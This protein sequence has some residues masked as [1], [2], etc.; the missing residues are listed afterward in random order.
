MHGDGCQRNKV[1]FLALFVV[2]CEIVCGQDRSNELNCLA[3]VC[4]F[5][6]DPNAVDNS[7]Q[8]FAVHTR[9]HKNPATGV[10]WPVEGQ[11]FASVYT[12]PGQKAMLASAGQIK[13]EGI[14]TVY[15]LNADKIIKFKYY[16]AV[17]KVDLRG[18]CDSISNCPWSAGADSKIS[19]FDH[20]QGAQFV[21]PIGTL[22]VLFFVDNH[23]PNQGSVAVDDIQLFCESDG[24]EQNDCPKIDPSP[25]FVASSGQIPLNSND[26]ENQV[27]QNASTK[28]SGIVQESG[29]SIAI[30]NATITAVVAETDILECQNVKKISLLSAGKI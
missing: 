15:P 10:R 13:S 26:I 21:C 17:D 8:E 30:P 5:E 25:N 4:N 20:W 7:W 27:L 18:C 29:A 23:G 14:R 3:I 11:S 9:T 24:K 28:D 6:R 2:S 22:K 16:K 19:D 12:K 1:Y